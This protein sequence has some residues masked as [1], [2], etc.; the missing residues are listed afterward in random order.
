MYSKRWVWLEIS[1]NLPGLTAGSWKSFYV[2]EAILDHVPIYKA[3]L[4]RK[5]APINSWDE[6]TI[7]DTTV[8][9]PAEPVTAAIRFLVSGF[10][11]PLD[12]SSTLTC[13]KTLGSLVELYKLSIK[14]SIKCLE[15]A[16]LD[17]IDALNFEALPHQKFLGFARSY[18]ASGGVDAQHTTLGHLIK[19]KLSSLL[20]YL[21]KSMTIEE[22]SSESG[23]LGK[24][25]IAVLLERMAKIQAAP[26]SDARVKIENQ[27]RLI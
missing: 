19:K 14:L 17:H 5:A 22:M 4:L 16:L 24:Q 25:L 18:Y 23:I 1:V 21:Q 27:G 10:L 11:A 2:P 20:P 15:V 8:S 26:G 6:H 9:Y 12:T 13:E 3:Q 7:R